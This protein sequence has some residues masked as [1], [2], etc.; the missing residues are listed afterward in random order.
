MRG[1][2]EELLI[3]SFSTDVMGPNVGNTWTI[4][5]AARATCSP[6]PY[7]PPFSKTTDEKTYTEEPGALYY[8]PSLFNKGNPAGAA[9]MAARQLYPKDDIV[10][11]SLGSGIPDSGLP[12]PEK[13]YL[14]V[15]STL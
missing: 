9:L 11:V 8:D 7:M 2:D 13:P 6:Y 12:H 15:S 5:D 14:T 3:S 4:I 1:R 10:V